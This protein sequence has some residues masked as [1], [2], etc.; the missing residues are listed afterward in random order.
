MEQQKSLPFILDGSLLPCILGD[1]PWRIL[2]ALLFMGASMTHIR[3]ITAF[4]IAPLIVPVGLS[5]AI[6]VSPG[7]LPRSWTD[8]PRLI[9]LFSVYALPTAYVIELVLGFPAWLYFQGRA[10]RAWSAFAA[11]GAALGMAYGVGYSVAKYVAARTMAYDFLSHP[12]TRGINPLSL[13]VA[14]PAGLASAI[15]FR[16]I[17]FPSQA[18]EE[19]KQP[20]S[21]KLNFRN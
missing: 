7:D 16:A 8:L 4:L 14:V 18:D 1:G 15:L 6:V 19:S 20:S 9:L 13:W 2:G 11:G 5:V 3:T 21:L 10:I 17:V 12:L